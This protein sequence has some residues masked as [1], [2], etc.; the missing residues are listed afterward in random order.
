MCYK[1]RKNN[2]LS[3]LTSFSI[4]QT[5]YILM[6]YNE[7]KCNNFRGYL[8]SWT[9]PLCTRH[10]DWEPRNGDRIHLRLVKR[11]LWR[12][13]RRTRRKQK[14]VGNS[15]V[16]NDFWKLISSDASDVCPKTKW[17]APSSALPRC[18]IKHACSIGFMI[19]KPKIKY[20]LW[21]NKKVIYVHEST[22]C[23]FVLVIPSFF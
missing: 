3:L 7:Q 21:K 8:I 12:Q 6:T 2:L 4:I 18:T 9:Y 16:Q 17:L 22:D 23:N 11:R 14:D 1:I 20:Q 15:D 13:R 19:S 5:F 10:L